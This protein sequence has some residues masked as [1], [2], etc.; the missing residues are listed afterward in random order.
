M[1]IMNIHIELFMFINNLFILILIHIDPFVV[2]DYFILS[3]APKFMDNLVQ[4]TI[5][6]KLDYVQ[7]Q[8]YNMLVFIIGSYDRIVWF[9]P[10][11][12]KAY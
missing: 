12:K 11:I 5:W 10:P 8:N 3:L 4:F 1:S 6:V 7:L 9:N 2:G